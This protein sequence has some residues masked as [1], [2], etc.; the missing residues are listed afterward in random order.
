MSHVLARPG[1]NYNPV[2]VNCKENNKYQPHFYSVTTP[3]AKQNKA[4]YDGI[5][6]SFV[7][8]I[9]F[10]RVFLIFQEEK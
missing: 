1:F 4:N 7:F 3:D 9:M 5:H 2:T 10:Y 8:T 6:A